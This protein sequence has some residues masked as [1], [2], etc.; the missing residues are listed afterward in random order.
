M[1]YHFLYSFHLEQPFFNIFRYITFR[2]SLAVMTALVICLVLGPWVIRKLQQYQIGQP[3][4]GEGPKSHSS[5]AGTPTMGGLIILAA[6]LGAI[7]LWAD[8]KSPYIWLVIFSLVFF[9]FIGFMDD[10]LKVIKKHSDGM[11]ARTK[12]LIQTIGAS[13]IVGLLYGVLN[14]STELSVPFFKNFHPDI[15]WLYIPFAIIV[16]VGASNAVNLTDGLDGLVIGPITVAA[17][18]YTIVTYISGHR[19]FAEYLIIPYIEG[20]G[21][22]AVAC[23]ALFGAGLGFLWFNS[24]PASV[25]MGDVGALPLGGM[26][27]TVAVISKHEVLLVLVGGLFVIEALSVIM[28]VISFKLWSKRIFLMAP[29]HHHF[30]L[31][32]WAEPKV[33]MRFWI[34]SIVMALLS[35]STL[36]LR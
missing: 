30:E 36:K 32:G 27:G 20:S 35:L 17:V 7:L 22:L 9:G 33:V 6:M 16:I 23:G 8:L 25:F 26:L 18:A 24:F 28:Q 10:Y 12:L 15:G 29:L 5:K 31:K 1:L 11:K 21:E 4:R 13:I 14:Y 2:I 19:G 3:I 34:I